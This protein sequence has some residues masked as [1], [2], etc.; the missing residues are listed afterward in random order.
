MKDGDPELLPEAHT[1]FNHLVIPNY[2]S[3][4]K[5]REKLLLAMEN[6]E[7]FGIV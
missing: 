6:S 5:L 2:P 1:C 7:G 4:E 3:K